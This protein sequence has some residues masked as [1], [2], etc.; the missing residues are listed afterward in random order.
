MYIVDSM[1]VALAISH[2]LTNLTRSPTMVNNRHSTAMVTKRNIITICGFECF[3]QIAFKARW[4]N[5][6]V[7][8]LFN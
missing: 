5:I 1:P 6:V 8:L 7:L 2:S 4:V 3:G